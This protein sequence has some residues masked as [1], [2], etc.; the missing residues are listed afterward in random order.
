[1]KQ[2]LERK[3]FMLFGVIFL[4]MLNSYGQN[5]EKHQWEHRVLLIFSEDKDGEKLKNQIEILSKDKSGL[6]ERKLKIYQFSEKQYTTDFNSIWF[7]SNLME[8]KYQRDA[9]DFKV[10][11]VGL[12]G[13]IK[14]EQKSI[15][16]I[17]QLFGIIDGMSLRKQELKS[18]N[19]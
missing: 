13:G 9:E 5:I 4:M 10:V 7:S 16:T 1:M 17:E 19:N 3:N 11:L 6:V 15:L 8:K 18:K 2:R 12:D 14:F